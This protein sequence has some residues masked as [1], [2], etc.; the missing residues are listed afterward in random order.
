MTADGTTQRFGEVVEGSVEALVAQCH[1]LYDAPPLGALVRARDEDPIYAVVAG[2]VTASL[3]PTRRA[4]ARG[5]NAESEEQV[6]REH[7]QLERLL[8][9]DVSLVVVGHE[10]DGAV[11][12]YLPSSPP[13]IHTFVYGCSP[14]EV[15][16]FAEHLDFLA[17]LAGR[18]L[19][20]GDEV[21]AAT[22]RQASVAFEQPHEFLV[23]SGRAVAALLASDTARL[24]S[25][26]RRLPL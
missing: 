5:E 25:L 19:V 14:E 13:R 12:Q 2:V 8:R 16:R 11:H 21:L 26:L 7:P 17:L 22:L 20:I 10:T 24:T 15:R 9:T 23:R 6:Y 3:D 18:G 1:R 4:V